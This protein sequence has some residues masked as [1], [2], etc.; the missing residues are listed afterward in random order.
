MPTIA[1]RM[2]KRRPANVFGA[3]FPYPI[4]NSFSLVWKIGVKKL[5]G[6]STYCCQ[7]CGGEEN[8]LDVIPVGAEALTDRVDVVL[9]GVVDDQLV[10]GQQSLHILLEVQAAN[11]QV[12]H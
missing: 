10:V 12:A 9:D 8:G 2:Q 1:K 6:W 5:L 4:T 3:M 11:G 7:D